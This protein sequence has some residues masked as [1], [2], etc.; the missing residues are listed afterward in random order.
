[1]SWV[2]NSEAL[3]QLKEIFRGTLSS[4]NQERHFANEALIEAR[5]QPEIENY[6]FYILVFDNT[7]RS[8]VRAAAGINLKNSIV[9]NGYRTR[10]DKRGYLLD[11]IVK[12]LLIDD[13]MVRNITG[14]VITSLFSLFGVEEWP[15]IIPHLIE[16]ASTDSGNGTYTTQEGA[17]SALTKICEDSAVALDREINGEV[18]SGFIIRSMLTLSHCEKSGKIRAMSIHCINQFF[19]LKSNQVLFYLDN[20]M[21]RLFELATDSD[22]QV[23]KNI[24]T[25]FAQILDTRPHKLVPHLDG[26]I[27]YCLHMMHDKN[28]EVALEACEFLLALATSPDTENDRNLFVPKLGAVLPVLLE[29]MVYSEEEIFFIQMMDENDN[30]DVVDRDEDIKPQNAKMRESH[31]TSSKNS[32]QKGGAGNDSDSESDVD[33]DEDDDL[34]LDQWSLRKCSAATL[35]ILSLNFP[36]EVLEV[37]LPILQERIVSHEWAVREAAILAFGAISKSCLDLSSDKLPT[38]IPFLVDRLQDNEA[39]V[40]QITCW[41]IS[42]FASWVSEE[43]YEGGDYAHYFQPTF[44][45]IVQCV[46]DNKKVVQEA[47]CSALSA[48][49][50]EADT[51]MV[52]VYIGPLLELFAKCF[53]KYQRKNLII[54]YD[55]VQ[56]FVEKMGYENLSS[57][58]EYIETLLPP[59]LY[60]WQ[61]L[62]DND[63]ALWPLLECMASIAA[64]LRELFAPY[65]VPAYERAIKILANCIQMDQ[66]C[67]TNPIIEAPEKDFMVTALDLVDGLIQGFG[68]HSV[69]LV[70]EYGTNLMEMVLICLEDHTDDV[71]Q[72]AYALLGDLAINILDA[73]VI[74]NLHLILLAI[75]NEINNRTYNSFPVYNNAIWALGEIAMR[76]PYEKM[77][78]YLSNLV[79]VVIPVLNSS[80]T[81]QT[82][83]ENAAICMGRMGLKGGAS[84][85]SLRLPEFIVQWCSQMIYLLDNNEKESSFEGMLNIINCNPDE[86]FGAL[87]NSQG[88][89]NLAAFIICI[90][91]YAEPP[92]HLRNMFANFLMSYK[93]LF[94]SETWET[95]IM[96]H[97][98]MET[99]QQLHMLYGV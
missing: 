30:A 51:S 47:A 24:C 79:N 2:P 80:D 99:R 83:V 60:K 66:Q 25:A 55:C 4:N 56:T 33:E 77:L 41:T 65:A 35:D 71:R 44:Q 23:R 59:L 97:I 86:G 70:R 38:L 8:D 13:S 3:G 87:S 62:D 64:T 32:N 29:K 49:I 74:P 12:G 6:L 92:E 22:S 5:H 91:N 36:A 63:S 43:A 94:G 52:A 46:L 37:S 89:K 42:R 9:G 48:F 68:A 20:I 93:T 7:A 82:V 10:L 21:Q 73:T 61:L 50:E 14:N 34:E 27:N 31:M 26:V 69:E 81:Q 40:R 98:D 85:I 67:Q 39:R 45:S 90:G 17:M 53:Q 57:K 96:M 95:Q 84:T 76:V 54:L 15:H 58:P 16:L 75:G 1:M 19:P 11:N 78:P 72:S 28:E 18:P 88:K